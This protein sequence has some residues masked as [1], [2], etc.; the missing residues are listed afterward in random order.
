MI[1]CFH[2]FSEVEYFLLHS[3]GRYP[4]KPFWLLFET[5]FFMLR[6]FFKHF[7]MQRYF[8]LF[9]SFGWYFVWLRVHQCE[10]IRGNVSYFECKQVSDGAEA[11]QVS[12]SKEAKQ[13]GGTSYYHF[14]HTKRYISHWPLT[15][16]WCRKYQHIG[17]E[18]VIFRVNQILDVL[19]SL[20]LRMS[21][22]PLRV[23][24]K[25]IQVAVVRKFF[26]TV[27]Y[28]KKNLLISWS[29]SFSPLCVIKKVIQSRLTD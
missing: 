10:C 15:N 1:S 8:V 13:I 18:R 7:W 26:S 28:Q 24:K 22:S 14:P 23:I 25:V 4:L 27:C 3:F 20:E 9:G 5:P 19:A 29:E 2:V 21:F 11:K 16:S 12:N 17:L 6:Y